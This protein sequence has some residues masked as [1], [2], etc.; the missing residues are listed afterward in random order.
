RRVEQPRERRWDAAEAEPRGAVLEGDERAGRGVGGDRVRAAAAVDEDEPREPLR[1]GLPAEVPGRVRGGD[2]AAERVAADDDLPRAPLRELHDA[3]E[4]LDL[5]VHPPLA[6]V[7]D[8][9]VGN[10]LEVGRHAMVREPAE[11]VV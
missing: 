6:R 9:R 1:A 2:R 5:D 8:L 7:G 3:A 4:V 11:I 10:E